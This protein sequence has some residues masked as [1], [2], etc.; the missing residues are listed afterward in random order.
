MCR[1]SV[2][3]PTRALTASMR[4]RLAS[5]RPRLTWNSARTWPTSLLTQPMPT[6]S[7]P[8]GE[9]GADQDR[10]RGRAA[11]AFSRWSRDL[12]IPLSFPM[13]RRHRSRPCPGCP[14]TAG[15]PARRAAA[16]SAPG[17]PP[18]ARPARARAFPPRH[19]GVLP[20]GRSPA[21]RTRSA[22]WSRSFRALAR[23]LGSVRR[24]A[25]TSTLW[26]ANRSGAGTL[27]GI[28]VP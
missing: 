13:R 4:S 17:P 21:P 7:R 24:R 20:G 26:T 15:G 5:M 9:G 23:A 14:T 12:S 16:S 2:L 28:P 1:R 22:A 11:A 19:P 10:H 25:A 3:S 6:A 27:T 8:N 18:C